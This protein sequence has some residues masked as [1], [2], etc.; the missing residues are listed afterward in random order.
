[1]RRTRLKATFFGLFI[2]T[3]LATSGW[4]NT[5]RAVQDRIDADLA[6]GRPIVVQVVVALCDNVHQGIVP[7]P[8]AIGNGQ[9]PRNNL[10]WGALYGLKTHFPRAAGWKKME[11][12]QSEDG[13]ILERV[14]FYARVKRGGTSVPVYIVA[15]AWDG[16]KMRE[17][18]Q[19]YSQMVSG[20]AG[21]LVEVGQADATVKLHAG[22]RAHLV[23]FVGHNGLMDF[24]LEVPG[25]TPKQQPARSSVVLACASKSY[26]TERLK[27]A[28]AHPLVL[29]TGLMAP[30]A[31]TLDAVIRSWAAG[32]ST[33]EVL[34]SAARAYH[35]YQKCGMKGARRLFWGA[36]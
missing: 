11:V 35:K 27:A 33:E 2:V 22:G 20:R 1:M 26:F 30:E 10:Y 7:V 23:A 28:D 18:L 6:E 4:A 16:A 36:P 9:A 19:A 14:V 21:Q 17:A 13:H 3:S 25:P 29:T 15:D 5:G 8:K 34:Q 32:K 12:K 24:S 31:Y